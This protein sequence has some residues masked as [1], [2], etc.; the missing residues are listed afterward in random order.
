MIHPAVFLHPLSADRFR[1]IRLP[2]VA[3]K[4]GTPR[5]PSR[6]TR[7]WAITAQRSREEASVLDL[8]W[9]DELTVEPSFSSSAT[10]QVREG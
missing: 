7:A 6:A 8:R 4:M 2:I 5:F 9:L 1:A 10:Q 3:W